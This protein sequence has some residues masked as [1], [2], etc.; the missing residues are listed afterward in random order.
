[1]ASPTS[2]SLAYLRGLLDPSYVGMVSPPRFP[3]VQVVEHWNQFA[4]RRIDLFG[5]IDILAVNDHEVWAVQT[6]SASNVSA[7]VA[8]ITESPATPVLRKLG[9]SLYVH[10]WRK[11][12][13]G[14]WELREVDVS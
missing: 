1:M 8:K 7:R 11:A 2:R 14:R 12:K 4:R 10:G 9:W 3:L 13:N 5:I 6:T